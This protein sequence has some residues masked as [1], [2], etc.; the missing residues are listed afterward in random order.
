MSE[1]LIQALG[2]ETKDMKKLAQLGPVFLL[3]GIAYTAGI[4]ASQSLFITRFGVEYL[5]LM[6]LI[7][8][9]LLPLQLWVISSLSQK[10]PQGTL[11]K[12]I[13][14]V[15]LSGMLLCTVSIFS[16]VMFDFEWL[17]FYPVVFL[18]CSILLRIMVP[19]MW[20]LGDGICMLQ[21]A[22]RIF[23]LL[24]AFFI[25]GGIISGLVAKML[26]AYFTGVGTELSIL[27][28]MIVT[29]LSYYLWR[30]IISKYFLS[31]DLDVKEHQEASLKVVIRTVWGAPLLRTTLFSFIILV[32]LYY[33]ID[34]QFFTFANIR[35]PTSDGFTQ[36]YGLYI[37]AL[38]LISFVAG[39]LINR[40][41]AR[42]GI[43]NTVFSMGISVLIILLFTGILSRTEWVLEAFIAADLLIDILAFTFLPM[44][45]Q[46]FYKLV[47]EGLRAGVSLLFAGSINAGGK[48][49]S[50][51]VTGLHSSGTVTWTVLSLLGILMA[52]IYL[53][54]TWKQKRLYFTTLLKS[55]ESNPVRGTE[56]ESFSLA[57][58]VGNG[59]NRYLQ[60]ALQSGDANKEMIAL[61]LSAQVRHNKMFPLLKPYLTHPDPRKRLLALR[62]VETPEQELVQIC[63]LALQDEDAE[64][65]CEAVRRIRQIPNAYDIGRVLVI[66][67]DDSSPQVIKET[68]I[69]L[70]PD[71]DAQM[72]CRIDNRVEAL[73][74]GNDECRY[75]V[76]QLIEALRMV[77][78]AP[79]IKANLEK[80]LTPRVKVAAVRALGELACLDS[81]PVML[82][83]YPQSDKELRKSI[84]LSIPKMGEKAAEYL[85]NGIN[86]DELDSWYISVV[87]LA[88]IDEKYKMA[89]I[90]T[91][92]CEK[93]LLSLLCLRDI[94]AYLDNEHFQG[95]RELYKQ[96]Y[97][98]NFQI[99]LEACWHVLA[100]YV[101][102]L[103][104]ERLRE[105][106][107]GNSPPDKQEQ[108]L[109]ILAEMESRYALAA[110]IKSAYS[111]SPLVKKQV[112]SKEALERSKEQFPDYWLERFANHALYLARKAG[113]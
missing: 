98:E 32:S 96:R 29:T 91:Q 37:A 45:N 6:Y 94:P 61:E 111:D 83:L 18:M 19:L 76:C 68:M 1:S 107:N 63:L 93:R 78:Y 89:E 28:M 66:Y 52:V 56:F 73:L 82:A 10:M 112:N 8:A 62:S 20:M 53:T 5:P 15:I 14:L 9:C 77:Q 33:I 4:L 59:D 21:Q 16:M 92:T 95:I 11:I 64:V 43:S 42:L 80:E 23:P 47:P 36:F 31:K 50:S 67:L 54:L 57:K 40:I 12:R 84:E 25:M 35:Y 88:A 113:A 26:A 65:R 51:A 81:I 99:I 110:R 69:A 2:I 71:A 7:E 97:Q 79:V 70:Y 39:L 17:G 75:Q 74:S 48:L 104:A 106:L 108:A 109:E 85:I 22:K 87:T 38:M 30:R 13:Y 102:N 105:A 101:D 24:G 86:T 27:L 60:Q 3:T 46:M 100:V 72:K 34:Y 44:I 58:M 55:L 90:L 103:I 49:I 41:F